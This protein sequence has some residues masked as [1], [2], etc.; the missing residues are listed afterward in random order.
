MPTAFDEPVDEFQLVTER[1]LK[2]KLRTVSHRS[3]EPALQQLVVDVSA[4]FRQPPHLNANAALWSR[5]GLRETVE[6]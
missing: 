6:N 3:R 4:G 1:A 5:Q 2:F